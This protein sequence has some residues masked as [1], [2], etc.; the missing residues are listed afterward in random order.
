MDSV[1]LAE[2]SAPAKIILFGEHAVVHGQPAIAAPVTAL[3]AR[4]AAQP[5]EPGTGLILNIA[6]LGQTLALVPGQPV[7]DH[8]LARAAALCLDAIQAEPVDATI[9][10]R[11]EIPMA[12]GLGSGAALTAALMRALI[13]AAGATLTDDALNGLVYEVEREFHG[14]PSGIDNTVVVFERALC[15]VR[16][17]PPALLAV[18]KPFHLIVADT[19]IQSS[20]KEAVGAVHA[21]LAVDPDGVRTVF[22]RIG[23]IVWAAREAIQAGVTSALGPLMDENHALLQRLTVSSPELDHLVDAA[24]LAGALG[25]K[26]SGGGRGGNLIAYA[27]EGMEES[28]RRALLNAGAARAFVTRIEAHA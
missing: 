3:R 28:V 10:L 22:G 26:L 6:D 8:P 4:A 13:S 21:L 7:P 19:G 2:A 24:R 11:S 1:R 25:A 5:A 14:T 27:A 16:G 12:S 9:S 20:T 17:Q 23:E 15:F 18:G